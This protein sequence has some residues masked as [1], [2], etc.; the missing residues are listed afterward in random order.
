MVPNFWI[1]IFTNFLNIIIIFIIIINNHII[2]IFLLPTDLLL[3]G[4]VTESTI[5]QRSKAKFGQHSFS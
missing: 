2:L 3:G 4:K 5:F 1:V